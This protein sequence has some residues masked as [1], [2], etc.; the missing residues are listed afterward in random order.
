MASPGDLVA[1]VAAVLG[2]PLVTISTYYRYLREAGLVTKGG[3]GPSAAQMSPRDAAL[4][5]LAVAASDEAKT[6]AERTLAMGLI[7]LVD[8]SRGR[9]QETSLL[10]V[11]DDLPPSH[12]F[13]D[14]LT[15]LLD[16]AGQGSLQSAINA[17]LSS[18]EGRVKVWSIRVTILGPVPQARIDIFAGG[19]HETLSY[20]S[21]PSE[22]FS[23]FDPDEGL[24]ALKNWSN[25]TEHSYPGDMS[26]TREF[27][28]RTILRIGALVAGKVKQ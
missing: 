12:T 16:C 20:S 22:L 2:Y 24:D 14:A 10:S 13:A 27:T 17:A 15:M 4:L 11:F 6:A 3:R 9:G 25:E 18:T 26:F 5:L 19:R 7:P 23:E 8:R 1:A 21:I 28:G